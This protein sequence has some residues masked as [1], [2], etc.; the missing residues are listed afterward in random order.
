MEA[1]MQVPWYP[2]KPTE[3]ILIFLPFLLRHLFQAVAL[4]T[5]PQ[6]LAL[7]ALT[8]QKNGSKI[9]SD[10]WVCNYN[11]CVPLLPNAQAEEL[12]HTKYWYKLERKI[13]PAWMMLTHCKKKRAMAGKSNDP[14]CFVCLTL[15]LFLYALPLACSPL[16]E[17]YCRMTLLWI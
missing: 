3:C 17:T 1:L 16:S 10:C 11:D 5:K 7:K 9:T 6:D 2:E 12:L 15:A 13:E 8:C 4:K 14:E